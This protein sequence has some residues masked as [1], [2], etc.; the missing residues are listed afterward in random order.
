MKSIRIGGVPEHFN[1]P[2]HLCIEG[3]EFNKEEINVIWKDFPD[4]TGAMNKALRSGEIDAAVI[5]TE[6]ITRDIINGN[7]AK[8][9]QTYIGSPL[10][11]G[12]HV[13]AD[14]A[15]KNSADLQ[16][17]KAAISREGSGSHLMAY[18]NAQNNGWNVDDLE[19][20]IVKDIDGAVKTLKEDKAQYFMWEHFTTKPLV[21][22]HTFRLIADCP[23]PWPCFVI[24]V[25]EEVLKYDAQ[26][27]KTML[28]VLNN[29]TAGFKEIPGID[30]MLA[31]RYD[32]KLE[33]IRK[34]LKLTNWSNSQ[35]SEA[36]LTEV[37]KKLLR[38]N[39]ISKQVESSEILHSL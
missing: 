36:E 2:W 33:D 12:I 31:E 29:K 14:S 11:W 18:V 26:R 5:L 15:Y 1:L 23:T 10:I 37:Q 9:V 30:V 17:T 8:I 38:L 19:F 22:N 25:R 13:A 32:Q 24:A 39:L 20:E 35:L 27:I 34:W 7:N 16:H 28:D 6:G 3:N 21:D 4:G